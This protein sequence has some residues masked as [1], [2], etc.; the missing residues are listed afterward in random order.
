MGNTG[1]QIAQHP[2]AVELRDSRVAGDWAFIPL[3]PHGYVQIQD[4][5]P[6]EARKAE[7]V[8]A[9]VVAL[10]LL[11]MIFQARI[12][13]LAK[14]VGAA[15]HGAAWLR[16]PHAQGLDWRR[17]S[18]VCFF[19]CQH[20]AFTAYVAFALGDEVLSWYTRPGVSWWA[21]TQPPL[22]APLHTYI[23]LGFASNLESALSMITNVWSGRGKDLPMALHHASTL[24]VMAIA[25]RCGFTRVY[26]AI[27]SLHDA[28]DLPIDALRLAQ[29][30]QC[31]RAT[32]ISAVAAVICWAALRGWIFPAYIIHSAIFE[33]R[34]I[35]DILYFW[36]YTPRVLIAAYA[37]FIPP[38]V[39]LWA[40]S[41]HWL[42]ALSLKVA[43]AVTGEGGRRVPTSAAIAINAG[44]V[45]LAATVVSVFI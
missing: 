25:Y 27:L 22:S 40:L 28:T 16:Q 34:H 42:R 44:I 11:R 36:G 3:Y 37:L 7:R 33:T 45:A 8:G 12:P 15:L 4:F 38:L 23:L 1:S 18:D 14:R 29:A 20:L 13:S 2:I 39:I 6:W 9:A 43:K 26:A 30:W 19:T 17:F 21:F 32:V 10:L 41:C 5:T 31:Q 24:F 35:R